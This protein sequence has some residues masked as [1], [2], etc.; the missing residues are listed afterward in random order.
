VPARAEA[1]GYELAPG[2][3]L[4]ISVWKDEDL[5]RQLEI[6]PDGIVSFPLI[7]DVDAKGMS[8]PRLRETIEKRLAEFIPDPTVTVMLL[9]AASLRAYVIGKVNNPGQ[10]PINGE[11]SVMQVLSMA[12]GLNPFASDKKIIVLRQ[13]GAKTIKLPFNYHEVERGENLEQN[14]LLERGDVVVVP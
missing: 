4:E 9:K 5:S 1:D 7:G 11:T 14:I 2:D 13:R 10:F 8:V 3:M 6:P 12:G